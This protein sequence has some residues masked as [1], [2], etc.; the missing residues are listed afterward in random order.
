MRGRERIEHLR[1]ELFGIGNVLELRIFPERW[2]FANFTILRSTENTIVR[3][4]QFVEED[5]EDIE[6]EFVPQSEE[7]AINVARRFAS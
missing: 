6:T 1:I 4:F 3:K 7:A 2:F 5:E